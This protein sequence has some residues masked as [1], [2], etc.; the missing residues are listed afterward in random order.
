M[1]ELSAKQMQRRLFEAD[2]IRW[3]GRVLLGKYAHYCYDWDCL[4]VDETTPEWDSCACFPRDDGRSGGR[5]R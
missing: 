2:C 3:H 1:T 4:P 5:D